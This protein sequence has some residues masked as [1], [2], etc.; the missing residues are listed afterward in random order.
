MLIVWA[1]FRFQRHADHWVDH[2]LTNP[3]VRVVTQHVGTEVRCIVAT[4]AKA[5]VARLLAPT[6]RGNP[7]ETPGLLIH[8]LLVHIDA[9]PAAAIL[10]QRMGWILLWLIVSVNFSRC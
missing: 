7:G 10:R 1:P 6:V 9:V 3:I 2:G 4:C 5:M 8:G